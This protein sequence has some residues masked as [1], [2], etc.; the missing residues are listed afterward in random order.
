MSTTTQ[1]FVYG[2]FSEG[3]I[4]F[5]KI[6]EFV[7][8]VKPAKVK[9]SVFRLQVGY[10]AY[11][12][13]GEDVVSGQVVTLEAPAVLSQIL[14]EFHGFSLVNPEKSLYHKQVCRLHLDGDKTYPLL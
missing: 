6:S 5:G 4:H 14:D 2:S 9:G 11:L 3:M 12:N 8:D 10:P 13:Q 7:K 1:L